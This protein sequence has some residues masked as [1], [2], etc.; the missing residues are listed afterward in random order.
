MV[1]DTLLPAGVRYLLVEGSRRA[2]GEALGGT[3][4]P[5]QTAPS[6]PSRAAIV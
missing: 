4:E 3:V 1:S 2:K 6:P 5:G